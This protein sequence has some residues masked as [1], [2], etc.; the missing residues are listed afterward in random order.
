[1][2]FDD[3]TAIFVDELGASHDGDSIVLADDEKKVTLLV[4]TTDGLM[5]IPKVRSVE[6]KS[7]YLSIRT[8]EGHTFV[9]RDSVFGVRSE[10]DGSRGS[11]RPGFG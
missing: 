3:L 8:E 7:T 10:D 2:N 9:S 1:M 5:S 6:A 4:A 11:S